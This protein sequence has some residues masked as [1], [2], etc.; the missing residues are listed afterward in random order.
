LA[1]NCWQSR[2][3]HKES[4]LGHTEK[5]ASRQNAELGNFK[6]RT[7]ETEGVHDG[8]RRNNRDRQGCRKRA[9][10]T[11]HGEVFSSILNRVHPNYYPFQSRKPRNFLTTDFR[12]SHGF[13]L[14][15][16]IRASVPSVVNMFFG[17]GLGCR[18][19][20]N[21]GFQIQSPDSGVWS[22]D[23]SPTVLV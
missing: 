22:Q 4:C 16:L 20:S 14:K 5:R 21:R 15:F 2:I 8:Q 19:G 1:G 3:C 17:C 13:V 18:L 6:K 7:K 23:G 12:I 11:S 9:P 10:P